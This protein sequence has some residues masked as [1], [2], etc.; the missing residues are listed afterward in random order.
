MAASPLDTERPLANRE[1]EGF[2]WINT[3]KPHRTP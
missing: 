3:T 2:S 1:P